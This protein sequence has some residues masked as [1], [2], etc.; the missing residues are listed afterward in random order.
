MYGVAAAWAAVASLCFYGM[1]S[2]ER[3]LPI[4]SVSIVFNYVVGRQLFL[5]RSQA[6]LWVGIACNLLF[7]AWFKYAGF[8]VGNL[9]GLG[10]SFE[11]PSI[12]LPIGISF[13]TFTQIAFLVDAYRGL[14]TEY[15]FVHYVLFVSYFPHLIAGPILHH[16]E[17]MPQF[18]KPQVYHFNIE[19][20]A[21]GISW[22][23]FGLFKKVVLA[24][25]IG[26]QANI[27][28]DAT[29]TGVSLSPPDAWLGAIS[30]TLQIY[31]DFS[32][33]SDMAIGLAVMM[34]IVFPQ[35][36]YSPYKS[37]SLIEFW[38]RWH[39]T[40]S[41]FL[42]D[43][44][45][46]PLGGSRNGYARQHLNLFVTMV[47]GGLWH[48]ASWNFV[49]WGMIHGGALSLNHL[50]R[51]VA[52]RYNLRLPAIV[53]VFLTM[54]V[55]IIAWVPFRAPTLEDTGHFWRAMFGFS[56]GGPVVDGVSEWVLVAALGAI[57]MLLPNT[58][59]IFGH[60][61]HSS[62]ISW[63]P[64]LSWAVVTSLALAWG[65]AWS[66]TQPTAFLYFRF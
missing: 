38:R 37:S 43:Y 40:L 56:G 66:I 15:R 28:F 57:A 21:L 46:I 27:V 49:I 5:R 31:F 1:E 7:L 2:L 59:Q 60:S 20:F 10:F 48:G 29:R 24:D 13:Y 34:G 42:R 58:M 8:I 35:N 4:I 62:V 41:R 18:A 23:A 32:G 53:G 30:Y 9:A 51:C 11:I 12:I 16:K 3:L 47:L 36:F 64:S 17:M 6:I 65:V 63:R 45:Y 25:S 22:F 61:G 54:F 52:A 19:D 33:Y 26:T 14:A 44:L 55:V 50:W 39:M